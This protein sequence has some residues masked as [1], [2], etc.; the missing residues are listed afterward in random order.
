MS[1]K[2]MLIML[3]CCLIPLI[4]LG[5][6]LIFHIPVSTTLYVGLVLLCPLSH[7]LMMKFMLQDKGSDHHP[8]PAKPEWAER[9][10]LRE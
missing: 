3:L 2:Y 8:S 1:K 4:G 10:S 6:V 7:L 5:A 9:Q